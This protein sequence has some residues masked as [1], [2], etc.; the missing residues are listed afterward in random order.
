MYNSYKYYNKAKY[1]IT[2]NNNELE[3][4]RPRMHVYIVYAY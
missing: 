3:S 4:I 2:I 1:T